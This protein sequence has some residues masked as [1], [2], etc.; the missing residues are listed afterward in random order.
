MH[1]FS[2]I[3]LLLDS[4]WL[5]FNVQIKKNIFFVE[6][7]ISCNGSLI[8]LLKKENLNHQT[9]DEYFL[10]AKLAVLAYNILINKDQLNYWLCHLE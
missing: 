6:Q 10:V 5:L 1:D 9:F 7:Y 8:I 4:C 3:L 2:L